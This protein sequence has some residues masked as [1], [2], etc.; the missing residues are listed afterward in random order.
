MLS[1]SSTSSFRAC[2]LLSEV[3]VAA[4][5]S[6]PEVSASSLESEI[7]STLFDLS[8]FVVEST[9]VS[10]HV[11][12]HF[13]PPLCDMAGLRECSPAFVDA[14]QAG[15]RTPHLSLPY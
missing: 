15:F 12:E 7:C 3:T 2:I 11:S 5:A 14:L 8:R 10:I 13:L 9:K 6:V 4:L 1:S